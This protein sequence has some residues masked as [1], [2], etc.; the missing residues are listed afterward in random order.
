MKAFSLEGKKAVI[1]G[2][3]SGIGFEIAKTFVHAGCEVLIIGRTEQKLQ[4]AQ[5]EL[6]EKCHY[7][8]FDVTLL[9]DI[10]I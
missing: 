5:K 10:P 7:I 3:G 4:D 2:G 9:Q 8:S 6:G 1:T